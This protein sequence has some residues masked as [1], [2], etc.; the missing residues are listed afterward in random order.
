[1]KLRLPKYSEAELKDRQVKFPTAYI[2]ASPSYPSSSLTTIRSAG[3]SDVASTGSGSLI[4]SCNWDAGFTIQQRRGLDFLNSWWIHQNP[5]PRSIHMSHDPLAFH[6]EKPA[7]IEHRAEK[8]M[9]SNGLWAQ[10]LARSEGFEP[11]TLGI[12][13]HS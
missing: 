11:P 4:V 6:D 9:K 1:M 8:A 7:R 3:V 2:V 5:L 13:I 10:Q 12:E